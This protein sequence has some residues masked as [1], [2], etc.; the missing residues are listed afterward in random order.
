M[1]LALGMIVSAAI[2]IIAD[3]LYFGT[4]NIIY[5]GKY[6]VTLENVMDVL[7]APEKIAS[8]R[9]TVSFFFFF[10]FFFF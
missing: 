2:L 6:V 8:I 1:P 5:D 7:N 10:F 3:S 4:L 9:F